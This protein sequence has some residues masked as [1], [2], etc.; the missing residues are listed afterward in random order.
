MRNRDVERM[1]SRAV[2]D[3]AP[4][5]LDRVL[6][7]WP[8]PAP[9]AA[10]EPAKPRRASIRQFAL[11]AAAMIV[12]LAGVGHWTF[13]LQ[14]VAL[15]DLDVN[16]AIELRFNRQ[17]RVVAAE[18]VN[19]D[20]VKVLDS[21]LLRGTTADVAVNALLGSMLKHGYLHG[22]ANTVLISTEASDPALAD[23]LRSQAE[24][25][26]SEAFAQC[27]FDGA[28]L[29]QR[30]D[31]SAELHQLATDHNTSLGKTALVERLILLNPA[32]SFDAVK[33][34]PI[35]DISLVLAS[36]AQRPQGIHFLGAANAVKY[37]GE[38]RAIE[39]ALACHDQRK[40]RVTSLTC[41]MDIDH[42]R[43]I[44]D[45]EF[46]YEQKDYEYDIDALTGEVLEWEVEWEHP[47]L[48]D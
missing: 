33:D 47:Q 7:N 45:V 43:L 8:T 46:C 29:S 15:L 18:P 41:E 20:G 34:V 16:P 10:L 44:Y 27:A 13:N 3:T 25:A 35:T 12:L 40:E 6:A 22:D 24:R 1:L 17:Q 32:L 14:S 38:A 37:I 39:I 48:A 21:M 23:A 9:T 11:A 36:K 5:V 2:R 31:G 26:A 4:D 30:V 42:S 28:V 19:A